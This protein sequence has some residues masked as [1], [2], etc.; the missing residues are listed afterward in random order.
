MDHRRDGPVTVFEVPMRSLYD[1]LR[2]AISFEIIG[3]LLVVPLGSLLFH[4][5]LADF[6]VVGLVS[7]TLATLWNIVYNYFFDKALQRAYGTTLKTR[8]MRVVHAAL[9]ELGLLVVLLP[10]IAW[11]L[12]VTVW[13]AFIM[14]LSF[15]A[16][17]MVYAFCFNWA[18]DTLFP[19][20]EWEKA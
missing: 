6:G 1:R 4:V 14:D 19:L 10:F 3:L 20:P 18:Y 5:P 17:Y 8:M 11:Y 9:F 13:Q 2:H 16:F 15:A 12:G 7:A